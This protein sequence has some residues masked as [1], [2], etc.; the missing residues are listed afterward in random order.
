MAVKL[1]I[2][3]NLLVGGL[4]LIKP[5]IVQPLVGI[6]KL[7]RWLN[8]VV[9][10]GKIGIHMPVNITAQI[11]QGGSDI[12]VILVGGVYRAAQLYHLLVV[13]PQRDYTDEAHADKKIKNGPG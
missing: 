10:T 8:I 13:F 2:G 11:I 1:G 3:I 7:D 5:G 4:H 6:L 9:T 12:T